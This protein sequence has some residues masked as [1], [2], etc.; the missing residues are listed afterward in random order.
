M[1]VSKIGQL[2]NGGV[3]RAAFSKEDREVKDLATEF[4]KEA[5]LSV[6]EDAVGNLIGRKEGRNPS[7][8]TVLMG[9]HL[10]TQP[11]G[12][13]FDG[14]LG[15]LGGI[16]VLHTMNENKVETDYPIEVIAFTG[17]EA[18]RF[19][20]SMI[21]SRGYTG[22]LSEDDLQQMDTEGITLAEAMEQA[23]YDPN[24]ISQAIRAKGTV[25]AYVELH[26]EQ[27]KVL[28]NKELSVGGVKVIYSQLR[29]RFIVKGEP[30]HGGNTPM[31]LRKEA[32]MAAAEIMLMVEDQAQK[33]ASNSIATV[34]EVNVPSTS[35]I[36]EKTEFNVAIRAVNNAVRDDFE[37]AVIEK[38]EQICERREVKLTVKSIL[39]STGAACSSDIQKKIKNAQQKLG[40]QDE[41]LTIGAGHDAMRIADLCPIGMI[42]VRSKDGLS[43]AP[44]EYSSPEDCKDGAN[45]LYHTI[46]QLAQNEMERSPVK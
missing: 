25:K 38:A 22:A 10:D 40:L 21:G 31:Y 2:K 45:V 16:E 24:A 39:K 41:F 29:D 32:L 4:M 19:K 1:A 34:G 44:G 42:L 35:G 46:L 27:G 8:P 12:G 14:V 26:I 20:A 36:P 7:Y 17:E 18:S 43:H 6:Y 33:Q 15:V 13:N 9:S 37:R 30:G 5:G 11:N 23:G 3:T 28:E